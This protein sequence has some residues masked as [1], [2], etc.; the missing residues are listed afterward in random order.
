MKNKKRNKSY[1]TNK[2]IQ[3]F[4]YFIAFFI[5][6]YICQLLYLQVFDGKSY[7]AKGQEKITT[8]EIV[9]PSRGAIYDRNKKP[10][11]ANLQFNTA[12]LSVAIPESEK[13]KLKLEMQSLDK[14][15]MESLELIEKYEIRTSLPGYI[16]EDIDKL[17]EILKVNKSGIFRMLENEIS[18]PIAY[19]VNDEIKA[20][21][22]KLQLPYISFYTDNE[23]YY[24]HEHMLA[25]ALGF[26]ENG[27]GIYGLESQYDQILSGQ[28]GYREYFKAI[29][30]TILP[31]ESNE[32]IE[33]QE[34]NNIVTTFDED[35]QRIIYEKLEDQFKYDT[36][37]YLTAILTDPNSGE[38][39]AMESLP[40]FDPNSPRKLDSDID[41]M[42]LSVLDDEQVGAYIQ[43]R[44]NNMAISGLYEPGS[45]FKTITLSVGLDNN[46]EIANQK[47]IC[48]GTIEIAPGVYIN[49]WRAHDPHGI[50]TL[51]EAFANSCN[52]AFVQ[53]IDLIGKDKFY[54]GVKSFKYGDFTGIDLPNEVAGVFSESSNIKDVDFKPMSYGHSLSTT[55]IQQ[56][57][58][59]NATINGGIY[60]R[61]HVL[62]EIM[63]NNDQVVGQVKPTKV[64][65][66]LSEKTSDT[67]RE[68]L[69]NNAQENY[70]T[71][72][73]TIE[74]GVK[75]G[76][77]V[78]KRESSPFANYDDEKNSSMIISVFATYPSSA[79][80]YSLLI[81]MS[82]P[83]TSSLGSALLPMAREILEEIEQ[84]DTN[85][86]SSE[87]GK[88][89]FKKIPNI[90][91]MPTYKAV[92]ALNKANISYTL[93]EKIRDFNIINSQYPPADGLIEGS[94]KVQLSIDKNP[95][96][97][98]PNLEGLSIRQAKRL[99][100]DNNIKYEIKGEGKIVNTQNPEPGQ[101]KKLSEKITITS[102]D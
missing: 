55:P 82:E 61:P 47:Y 10:L 17:S 16:D 92:E 71:K 102:G 59:L 78:V 50:Q 64:S 32:N 33:G 42:F 76:S 38:I 74:L 28:K 13:E 34:A 63:D 65:R 60:Y 67:V 73:N 72:E 84:L 20:E 93:D 91:G 39:L 36:P 81:V 8:K 21:V 96:Y 25:S 79:P 7:K 52:P 95:S 83:Q 6:I 89:N 98:V 22:E 86:A 27:K 97:E 62:K 4:I 94:A 80:K 70:Q 90:V 40:S 9:N 66:V 77:T 26:V 46:H 85:R 53:I 100:E 23:R 29:G 56:I 75:T 99:L 88:G 2:K 48:T 44:W 58:A 31:F 41:E 19:Q 51:K 101:I 43:S 45:T 35:F 15:D 49:C 54:E 24:P 3:I 14:S 11:A 30:G 5:F 18:G 37:N 12:Y 57:S 1:G 87:L 69:E 68:Y